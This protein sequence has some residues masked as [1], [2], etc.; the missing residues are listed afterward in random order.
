MS[1]QVTDL[2]VPG[3]ENEYRS[4]DPVIQAVIFD[5][6]GT[7]LDTLAD[8]AQAGNHVLLAHGL[9]AAPIEAYKQYVGA[10]ARNLLQRAFTASGRQLDVSDPWL[11]QLAGEFGQVYDSC[12]ALQTKP[13]PGIMTL[14]EKLSS[15]GV[16][17]M[18]LSNKPD[19]FTRKIARHFFAD[20]PFS[21]VCGKQT[22]WPL[23]PDPSLALDMCSRRA[24]AS[25]RTVF[26]GDSGSDM[27]TARNGCFL[28]LG[29]LW[30]FRSADEL[31]QN[32]AAHLFDEPAQ[33]A[34]WLTKHA[35]KNLI[36]SISLT[37]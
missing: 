24:I 18:I 20:I 11:D 19:V 2:A 8:L 26:A 12:W 6:D 30:G 21:A 10:G 17:L 23:K 5:L 9:P 16:E 32:G 25:N 4:A 37:R 22:G 1:D 7:L 15:L 3:R 13:Y 27:Q 28:P 36:R 14:L 33:L 34:E 35:D 29:V 31:I